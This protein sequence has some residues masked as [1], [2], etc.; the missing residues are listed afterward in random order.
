MNWLDTQTQELL[1]QEP[2]LKLAPPKAAEFGLVLL[3]KWVSQQRLVR[4]ICRIN[5][6]SE[7]DAAHLLRQPAPVTVNPDLAYEDALVG[8]FELICC[9]TPAAVLSSEVLEHG[10]TSYLTSLLQK[11]SRSPEFRPCS[12]TVIAIPRTEDGKKFADQFLGID[13][14]G[15]EEL[16]FP[17]RDEA[18][19][20]K[21]R[22]MKH[23]AAR[24]GARLEY[25]SI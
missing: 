16:A 22:I 12:M 4:A 11:I 18:P 14:R 15:L 9:D 1:Q 6:C 24:I 21:A 19:F 20:K 8:Q 5:N 7:S 3:Q 2:P 23:W 10:D 13:G 25:E 17:F